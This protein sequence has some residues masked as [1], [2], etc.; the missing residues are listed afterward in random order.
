MPFFRLL[1]VLGYMPPIEYRVI[2][3]YYAN[4][5][6]FI[7]EIRADPIEKKCYYYLKVIPG[8][9]GGMSGN[10]CMSLVRNEPSP[11]FLGNGSDP[12]KHIKP[13][14]GLAHFCVH[15]KIVN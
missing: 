14:M 15:N 6:P 2:G 4:P 7:H 3:C 8:I 10:S 9:Q 12:T 1:L 11:P 13:W 5:K